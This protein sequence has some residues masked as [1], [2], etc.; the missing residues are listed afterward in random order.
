MQTT[1]FYPVLLTDHIEKDAKF[2]MNYFGFQATFKSDWYISLVDEAG[3]EL[4][5]LD[6]SHETIPQGF[7]GKSSH[8]ILN[9]EKE[10]IDDLYSQL[11]DKEEINFVLD[12]KEEDFG[13]KHFIIEGPNQILIDIIKV[14]PPTSEYSGNYE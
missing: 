5:F 13:Q 3:H 12:L 6:E 10:E 14:I 11:K 2:F 8:L 9:F 7:N 4:A 1:S